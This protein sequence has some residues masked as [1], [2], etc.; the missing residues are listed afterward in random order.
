MAEFD[1]SK[2]WVATVRRPYL[3]GVIKGLRLHVA[4]EANGDFSFGVI[5]KLPP[6]G[7]YT[8]VTTRRAKASTTPRNQ[9]IAQMD[10]ATQ[11]EVVAHPVWQAYTADV[12]GPNYTPAQRFEVTTERNTL[13]SALEATTSPHHHVYREVDGRLV[14]VST[15]GMTAAAVN[16]VLTILRQQTEQQMLQRP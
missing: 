7:T 14:S 15:A 16:V 13:Y 9:V 1:P 5:S 8:P 6:K 4:P 3:F 10:Q 2:P 11:L 12:Q